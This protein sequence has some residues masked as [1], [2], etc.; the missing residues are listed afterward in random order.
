MM[1]AVALLV[2]EDNS[3]LASSLARGLGEEGYAVET[4]DT[5]AA[6]LERT[7]GRDIDAMILDLGLPDLADAA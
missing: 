4:F 6:A 2:V 1:R 5:G 3:R 7:R